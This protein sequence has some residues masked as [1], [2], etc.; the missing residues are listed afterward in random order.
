MLPEE[1]EGS[2]DEAGCTAQRWREDR[3]CEECKSTNVK[4]WMDFI[5]EFGTHYIVKLYAGTS[6]SSSGVGL[7]ACSQP[8]SEEECF[9]REAVRA[10]PLVQAGRRRIKLPSKTRKPLSFSREA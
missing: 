6:R 5:N 10:T 1:F 9:S 2:T 4:S 3:S 7:P 8:V